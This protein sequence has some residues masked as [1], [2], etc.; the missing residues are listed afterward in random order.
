MRTALSAAEREDK[1]IAVAESKIAKARRDIASIDKSIAAKT[2]SLRSAEDSERR[3]TDSKQK[4]VDSRRRQEER[5]HAREIARLSTPSAQIRYVEL[6]LPEPEKLR[7][8]YLT[9]NPEATEE[10]VTYPDGTIQRFGTWLRVDQEVRQVRQALRGSKYRDLV[11]VDHAPAATTNDLLDR[12]NDCRPHIVHFSGHAGEDGVLMENEAGDEDGADVTFE[13]LARILGATD[14]PPRLLVLNACKSLAG[15]DA[16]LQTVPALIGMSDTIE[17]TSAIV[18]ASA[19][20]SAI[21]SAQ[22]LASA[23][24]QAK[25]RMLAATLDGSDLP[26]LRVRNDVDPAALVLVTPLQM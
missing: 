8:L 3:S 15:A 10:T 12:L 2:T 1:K 23:L 7:V 6:R 22:S 25:V 26:E 16:L 11:Q 24:E 9:A 20:Y 5:N 18:F 14:E 19:L 13:L 17:D 21:A 4:Q